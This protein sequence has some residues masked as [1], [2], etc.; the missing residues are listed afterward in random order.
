MVVFN[1]VAISNSKFGID[2]P[3]TNTQNIWT[4]YSLH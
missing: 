2:M 3:A 1:T 4:N